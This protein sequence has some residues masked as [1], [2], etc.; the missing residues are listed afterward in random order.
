MDAECYKVPDEQATATIAE[1]INKYQPDTIITFAPDGSTGHPDHMAISR[2]T[3]AAAKAANSSARILYA[4]DT[5]EQYEAYLKDI[6][7]KFDLYFNV[8]SPC[9]VPKDECDLILCLTP[10]ISAIKFDALAAMP[11]QTQDIMAAF[12]KETF[13]K[14]VDCEA[15]VDCA[16][17]HTWATP[18][19]LQLTD[20]ILTRS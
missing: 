14:V 3:L 2:W 13:Q 16:T 12:G 7:Q 19:S 1:L 18:R 17:T 20:E 4:V 6:H 10:E 5:K 8:V 15:F 9:P 11:S